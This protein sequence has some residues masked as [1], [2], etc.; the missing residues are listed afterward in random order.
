MILLND[1]Y[2]YKF[3]GFK[4]KD[5]IIIDRLKSSFACYNY[6]FG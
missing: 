6:N 4:F 5:K 3:I 2:I 1:L